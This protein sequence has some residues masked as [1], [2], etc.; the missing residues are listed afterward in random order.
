MIAIAD[1]NLHNEM[2]CREGRAAKLSTF[3][4]IIREP[5]H[6][7]SMKLSP[8]NSILPIVSGPPSSPRSPSSRR[9]NAIGLMQAGAFFCGLFDP[10]FGMALI[11]FSSK[12]TLSACSAAFAA[13]STALLCI[14]ILNR[15][16]SDDLLQG[17]TQTRLMRFGT[18]QLDAP[19]NDQTPVKC[20]FDDGLESLPK[21]RQYGR[22]AISSYG[23]VLQSQTVPE[24][25]A[26]LMVSCAAVVMLSMVQLSNI[27]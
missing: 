15:S 9:S 10:L 12:V 23:T 4:F 11:I 17:R 26:W 6:S 3:I 27:D 24:G 1:T 2:I 25:V 13:M 20:G 18:Y 19:H 7:T 5:F 16:S 22:R 14:V 21:E 8:T